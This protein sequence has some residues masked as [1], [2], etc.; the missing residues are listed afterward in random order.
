MSRWSWVFAVLFVVSLGGCGG[1]G[2]R[3]LPGAM[4][5]M[6]NECNNQLVLHLRR[7][8]RECKEAKD[9]EAG[10][11]CA[12]SPGAG[13]CLLAGRDVGL[14]S[15]VKATRSAPSTSSA[16]RQCESEKD[17]PTPDAKMRAVRCR[18]SNVKVCA[19]P[20]EAPNG[21]LTAP[22]AGAPTDA[23]AD[24]A[25]RG[26]RGGSQRRLAIRLAV[27]CSTSDAGWTGPQDP[28]RRPATLRAS[29]TEI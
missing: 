29:V 13:V 25:A 15:T 17:C 27:G 21:M 20:E 9:C 4:C 12:G 24:A 22:D 16:G 11:L 19:E 5:K 6:S 18:T 7:V 23:G 3:L 28:T 10:Q 14:H 26:R 8:S 1:G 2:Q